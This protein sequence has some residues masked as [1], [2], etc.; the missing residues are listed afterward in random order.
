MSRFRLHPSA[1]PRTPPPGQQAGGGVPLHRF[2][3]DAAYGRIYASGP[4]AQTLSRVRG[5][6]WNYRRRVVEL[7][8]TLETFA[9]I[10]RAT[11]L[12]SG[13]LAS[14]CSEK[15][16]RWARAAKTSRDAIVA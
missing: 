10:K 2:K 14:R 6:A 12:R 7:S 4:D 16:L 15:L 8:L 3:L 11:G 1:P 9:N 13:A 5:A